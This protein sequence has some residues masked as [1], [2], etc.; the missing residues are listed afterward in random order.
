M[1][2]S[3]EEFKCIFSIAL[4]TEFSYKNLINMLFIRVE[5]VLVKE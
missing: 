4:E 2:S 5:R 3:A 1:E